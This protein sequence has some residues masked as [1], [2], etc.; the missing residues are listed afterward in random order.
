MMINNL[1]LYNF[2]IFQ[3]LLSCFTWSCGKSKFR[4]LLIYSIIKRVIV[5]TASFLLALLVT[6]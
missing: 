1:P 6:D 4:S 3:Y 5:I 2:G